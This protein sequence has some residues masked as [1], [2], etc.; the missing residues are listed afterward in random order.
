MAPKTHVIELASPAFVRPRY[1]RRIQA[2]GGFVVTAQIARARRFTSG[3][4]T[5]ALR[6]LQ[7]RIEAAGWG[8]YTPNVV[9]ASTAPA[10]GV[11]S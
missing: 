11:A 8:D 10:G 2:G 1:V 4:A 3:G 5:Q 6:D 9:A 7:G